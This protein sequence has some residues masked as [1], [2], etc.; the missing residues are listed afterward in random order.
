MG[1]G[2]QDGASH[3]IR[4]QRPHSHQN[5]GRNIPK[6]LKLLIRITTLTNLEQA[7]HW[8]PRSPREP[9]EQERLHFSLNRWAQQVAPYPCLHLSTLLLACSLEENSYH[10]PKDV[11]VLQCFWEITQRLPKGQCPWSIPPHPLEDYAFGLFWGKDPYSSFFP[12]FLAT[13]L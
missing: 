13:Q 6:A 12:G 9:L 7:P 2:K 5:Q 10:R 3:T 11:W 1:W 4:L 8:A